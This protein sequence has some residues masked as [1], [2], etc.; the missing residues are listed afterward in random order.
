MTQKGHLSG[1]Q[2]ERAEQYYREGSSICRMGPPFRLNLAFRAGR[3]ARR[4]AHVR[5]LRRD[6]VCSLGGVDLLVPRGLPHPLVQGSARF[7]LRTT[8]PMIAPGQ[9]VL[10]LDC[11]AGLDG[12]AAARRGASVVGRDRDPRAVEATR[13]NLERAGLSGEV[14]VGADLQGGPWDLVLWNPDGLQD[15]ESS[16]AGLAAALGERGRLL[17]GTVTGSS[18]RRRAREAMSDEF[19]IVPLARSPGLSA[20][21]EV[22]CIGFDL[23]AAR[24]RRHAE[25]SRS[26]QEK[27]AVSRRRWERGE[28]D[29]SAEEI[30]RVM[31]QTP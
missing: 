12:V 9:R 1:D 14:E 17:L 10:V 5:R 8:G 15:L 16:L 4:L 31:E 2:H 7:F 30:A 21:Y 18:A 22:L 6:D 23:E 11:G 26:A 13:A 24:A 29:A 3:A 28:T 27:A 25:R 19:R 20:R